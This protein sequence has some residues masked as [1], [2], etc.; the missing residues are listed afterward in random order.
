MTLVRIL[1]E[2]PDVPEARPGETRQLPA[3]QARKLID[4]GDA[5]R[6]ID[7]STDVERTDR[8]LR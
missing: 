2:T 8:R 1:R 4:R 3:G 5:A 6:V 7:R